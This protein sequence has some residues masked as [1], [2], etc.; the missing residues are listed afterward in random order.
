[1]PKESYN[2]MKKVIHHGID[3]RVKNSEGRDNGELQYKTW[4]PGRL[5]IKRSE[6][7]EAIGQQQTK[8]WDL[9]KMKTEGT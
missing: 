7:N 8:V 3:W 5:Q 6:D 1:M 4:K 9:G 2:K